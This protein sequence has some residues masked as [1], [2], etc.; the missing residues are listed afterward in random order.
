[1]KQKTFLVNQIYTYL[2]SIL[3][4]Q[5][6]FVNGLMH[7]Y[8]EYTWADDVKYKVCRLSVDSCTKNTN[9]Q[10]TVIISHSDYFYVGKGF[11]SSRV[12]CKIY[13]TGNVP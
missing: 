10:C 6:G 4:P 11:I 5:G 3:F 12:L 1:M 2:F 13:L 7:G 8:G 9:T